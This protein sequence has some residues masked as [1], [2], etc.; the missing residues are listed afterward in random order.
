MCGFVYCLDIKSANNLERAFRSKRTFIFRSF[1]FFLD[2]FTIKC[3]STFVSDFISVHSFNILID[4]RIN[5]DS[6]VYCRYA[7]SHFES[8][9]W[10]V[11]SW[12]ILLCPLTFYRFNM[13]IQFELETHRSFMRRNRSHLLLYFQNFIWRIIIFLKSYGE[14]GTQN[15]LQWNQKW[16]KVQHL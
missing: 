5:L 2:S 3:V 7:F 12:L 10:L 14:R 8:C 6:G 1:F 11:S 15:V 9:S 16:F 4:K 13:Y